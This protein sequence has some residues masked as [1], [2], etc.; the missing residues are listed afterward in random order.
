MF[1][2]QTSIPP[3]SSVASGKLNARLRQEVHN[4]MVQFTCKDSVQH[5]YK[6]KQLYVTFL[7]PDRSCWTNNRFRS[8]IRFCGLYLVFCLLAV[9]QSLDPQH[10]RADGDAELQDCQNNQQSIH[11]SEKHLVGCKNIV[12]LKVLKH[13]C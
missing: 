10:D 9:P 1:N 3:K 5:L 12:N 7:R 4:I 13:L 6:W 8:Q 2:L 11:A